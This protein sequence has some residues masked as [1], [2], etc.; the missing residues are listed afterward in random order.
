MAWKIILENIDHEFSKRL[1]QLGIQ[2][3]KRNT[4]IMH[5][6][7]N[8]KYNDIFAFIRIQL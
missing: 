7:Q 1:K 6:Y 2:I 4:R 5:L 8:I 3:F